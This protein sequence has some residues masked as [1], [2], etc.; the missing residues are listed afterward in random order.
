M[1]K[2]TEYSNDKNYN[3]YSFT[4]S[5]P[6]EYY[7]TGEDATRYCQLHIRLGTRSW[8]WRVPEFFKPKKQWV[9]TSQYA[10][11]TSK[12]KGYWEYISHRYG[13]HIQ[14]EYI[15]V[16]YGIQPGCWSSTDRKN[17]DHS[18]LIEIPWRI[19]RQVRHSF[20]TLTWHLFLSLNPEKL[21]REYFK[22][23]E[24]AR[25]AVPKIKFKF[26]DFDGEEIIATCFIEERQYEKGTG[27]FK[28]LKYFIKP[29]FFRTLDI[30]FDKEVGYEKGSWKGGTMGHSIDIEYGESPL[31]AFKRYGSAEDRYK[32]YGTKNRN[33]S[34]IQIT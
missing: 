17:S 19:K 2:L 6:H 14:D 23:M 21:G 30:N 24:L 20:M 4:V 3:G 12:N 33:F 15:H 27:W 25:E 34:N 18:K 16:H 8:S 22:R 13:F 5:N 7:E 29:E 26:N 1:I 31:E 28:W 9:D 32:N 11:S 10:W